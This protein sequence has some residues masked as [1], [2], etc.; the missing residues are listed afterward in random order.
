MSNKRSGDA[1]KVAACRIVRGIRNFSFSHPISSYRDADFCRLM[2]PIMRGTA[3]NVAGTGW[4][5]PSSWIDP[6]PE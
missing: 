1:G 4:F 2:L 6:F 5:G 3:G